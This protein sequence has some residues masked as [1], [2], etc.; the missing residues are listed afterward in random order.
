MRGF[1]TQKLRRSKKQLVLRD[2][3]FVNYRTGMPA[4][5]SSYD[6]HLYKL[7]ERAGIENFS[8]HALRHTYATRAIEAGV[9]A[10]VLQ[11][12]LGHSSIKMTLDR[13]VHVT[14]DAMDNA[15]AKFELAYA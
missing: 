9:D 7:C 2:L 10:K 14:D 5:N 12:I 11:K 1:H 3:V 4:K 6:T 15:I 13:Y 8:M